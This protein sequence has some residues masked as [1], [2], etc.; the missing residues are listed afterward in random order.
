[1]GHV[2]GFARSAAACRISNGRVGRTRSDQFTLRKPHSLWRKVRNSLLRQP[3]VHV[4][5]RCHFIVKRW[6]VV[7]I[8]SGSA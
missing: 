3:G 1:M 4:T 5:R 6:L 2:D 7:A 8:A